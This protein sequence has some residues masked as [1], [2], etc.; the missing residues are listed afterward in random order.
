MYF[1]LENIET[2]LIVVPTR[3][4]KLEHVWKIVFRD[5]SMK[6]KVQFYLFLFYFRGGGR[7]TSMW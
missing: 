3:A 1:L 5:K 7:E 6:I 2:I 4:I